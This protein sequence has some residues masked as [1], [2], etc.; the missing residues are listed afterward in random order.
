MEGE[1]GRDTQRQR[2]G[3]RES[4]TTKEKKFLRLPCESERV[5]EGRARGGERDG[6]RG[7]G[8]E[9]ERG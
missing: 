4:L 7:R 1:R 6:R 3:G 5:A 8:G 2:E 9:R